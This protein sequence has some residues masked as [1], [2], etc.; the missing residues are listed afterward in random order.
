MYIQ[1]YLCVFDLYSCDFIPIL[2]NQR[3]KSI[4]FCELHKKISLIVF[5]LPIIPIWI[6]KLMYMHYYTNR[7]LNLTFN[8]RN[9]KVQI[10]KFKFEITN[11]EIRK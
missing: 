5:I 1:M 8:F 10:Q 9:S 11:S 7:N 3:I 2:G 4:S 6:L